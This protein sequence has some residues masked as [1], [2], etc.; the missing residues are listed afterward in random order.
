MTT[1][2]VAR[3]SQLGDVYDTI[4]VRS[5]QADELVDKAAFMH[6]STW[7]EVLLTEDAEGVITGAAVA[8]HHADTRLSVL[9]YLAVS[10]DH[11]GAGSGSALLTA[12]VERWAELV[13]PGALLAEIERPDAHPATAQ[14]GDPVRRLAFYQR[15]GFKALAVPYY[16]PALSE[17]QQPVP[18]LIL[19]VLVLDP[20]WA[21][22]DGTRFLEGRRLEEVLT[23]RI[24]AP[25]EG[26]PSAYEALLSATRDPA[27]VELVELSDYARIPRSGP[28]G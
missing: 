6:H 2:Q 17:T 27:G 12:A 22:Q 9:E 19:G 7:G 13:S 14:F 28:L 25:E 1:V 4:L 24:P 23:H 15:H 20:A 21:S 10:P 11:R 26:D 18:D 5:F 8:D 16:Q 3:P